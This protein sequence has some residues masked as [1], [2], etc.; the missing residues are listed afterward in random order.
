LDGKSIKYIDKNKK[1]ASFVNIVSK[2][3]T[4]F[5]CFL[6]GPEFGGTR[7]TE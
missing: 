4:V 2:L 1:H 7:K 5:F 3:E 6:T